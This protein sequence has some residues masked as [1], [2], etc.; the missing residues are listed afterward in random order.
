MKIMG[1]GRGDR[2]DRGGSDRDRDRNLNPQRRRS[3]SRSPR[4]QGLRQNKKH[5]RLEIY[6]D[7]DNTMYY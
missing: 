1:D 4:S 5:K 6:L 2:R 7:F 3:R